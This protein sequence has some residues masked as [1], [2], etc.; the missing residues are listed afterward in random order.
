MPSLR[1]YLPV[2]QHRMQVDL[3]TREDTGRWVLTSFDRQTDEVR[4]PSIDCTLALAEIYDRI[5]FHPA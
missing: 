3:Y 1:E 2:A 5:E 4:L